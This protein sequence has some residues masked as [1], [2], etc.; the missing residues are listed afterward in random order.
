MLGSLSSNFLLGFILLV[1]FLLSVV[2]IIFTLNSLY[3]LHSPTLPPPL[4]NK[5]LNIR[6]SAKVSRRYWKS[7]ATSPSKIFNFLSPTLTFSFSSKIILTH[8][9]GSF[10]CLYLSIFTINCHYRNCQKS[11]VA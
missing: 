10:V 2:G 5:R 9:F 11:T 3:R 6:K 1:T 8:L 4:Q 7:V